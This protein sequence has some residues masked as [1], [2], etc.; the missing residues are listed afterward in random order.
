VIYEWD[1]AKRL[2][3]IAKHELDF[4][5]ADLV[6]ESLEKVTVEVTRAIDKEIRYA[7]FAKV[8][9]KIL[10]FVYTMRKKRIRCISFRIASQNERKCYEKAKNS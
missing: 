7:D 2:K 5:D 10:K 3:N 9:G 6:F 4:V 1:K 8:K